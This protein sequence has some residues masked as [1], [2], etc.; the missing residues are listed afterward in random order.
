MTK[1]QAHQFLNAVLSLD[2]IYHKITKHKFI[3]HKLLWTQIWKPQYLTFMLRINKLLEVEIFIQRSLTGH[4]KTAKKNCLLRYVA[5]LHV[6]LLSFYHYFLWLH[7][8]FF[9][10]LEKEHIAQTLKTIIYYQKH[11]I[12]YPWY[13]LSIFTKN[14]FLLNTIF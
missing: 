12:K 4:L 9:L 1:W 7:L 14:Q 8:N 10:L 6:C 11:Y 5:D 3:F 2:I 13:L